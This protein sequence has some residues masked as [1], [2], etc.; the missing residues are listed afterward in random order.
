MEGSSVAK[1]AEKA[2]EK[3]EKVYYRCY[4][5]VQNVLDITEFFL[6]WSKKMIIYDFFFQI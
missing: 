6:I 4:G 2:T 3:I 5:K 1:L